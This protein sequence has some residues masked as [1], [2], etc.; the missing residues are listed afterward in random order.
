[1]VISWVKYTT[2]PENWVKAW[3]SDIFSYN[4]TLNFLYA[5]MSIQY[6]AV[7]WISEIVIPQVV[8]WL[9]TTFSVGY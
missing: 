6:L 7:S 2:N 1:M 8:C 5:A 4:T 9:N 3:K